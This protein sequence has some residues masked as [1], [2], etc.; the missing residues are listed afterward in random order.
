MLCTTAFGAVTLLCNIGINISALSGIKYSL[1][2]NSPLL[3]TLPANFQWVNFLFPNRTSWKAN[4]TQISLTAFSLPVGTTQINLHSKDTNNLSTIYYLNVTVVDKEAPLLSCPQRLN[5]N[6]SVTSNIS[7]FNWSNAGDVFQYSDNVAVSMFNCTSNPPVTNFIF[8]HGVN[9]TLN[10]SAI[11]AAR[12]SGP[13]C[14]FPI[15]VV[16]IEVPFIQCP[17]TS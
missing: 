9:Y 2:S 10:C 16:D 14:M 15:R 17:N 8:K 1:D 4:G 3:P 7:V 6:T 13:P 12:N 5:I 11:D